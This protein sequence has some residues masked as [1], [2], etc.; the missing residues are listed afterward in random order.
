MKTKHIAIAVIAVVGVGAGIG[1][2]WW[3]GMSQG[4]KM[5]AGPE[6][7]PASQGGPQKAGDIDPANGKKVLYWHDPMVPNN[8]F[9][10]PGKSPFMD[11]M[12]V[13]KYG[14]S[15][16]ADDGKVAI[17]PRVQQNLGVRTAEV[18]QGSF[19]VPVEANGTVAYNE[20]DV[21]VVSTRVAGTLEKLN[22]R[23]PLE[24][25]KST[26]LNSSHPRL[27]RMPSSA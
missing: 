20:R 1:G 5:A 21:S 23:A 3:V 2:G 7:T 13:P 24:D 16:E 9:D 10:K 6:S 8:R 15:G 14:E 11:M 26:R 27:S 17:S 19:V 25:R 22:V 12:L 4:M 18:T